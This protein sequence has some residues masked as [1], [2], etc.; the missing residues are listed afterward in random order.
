MVVVVITSGSS[1]SS[2]G[3][4]S[5]S[6]ERCVRGAAYVKCE[7]W[8]YYLAAASHPGVRG[9]TPPRP[10]A[11]TDCAQNPYRPSCV[12][13]C[14]LC[15][16]P[17]PPMTTTPPSK[18]YY[19]PGRWRRIWEFSSYGSNHYGC[20]YLTLATDCDGVGWRRNWLVQEFAPDSEALGLP[21]QW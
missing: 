2:S 5:S 11:H 12:P 8:H 15:F 3:S 10:R 20:A 17:A 19:S 7:G 18:S 13:S 21:G 16:V 9:H 4:S 1:S 14:A 6:S